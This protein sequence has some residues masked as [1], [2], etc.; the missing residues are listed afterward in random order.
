MTSDRQFVTSSPNVTRHSE[1]W[2]I[3]NVRTQCAAIAVTILVIVAAIVLI[4]VL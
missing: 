4:L 1:S 3:Y 2:P